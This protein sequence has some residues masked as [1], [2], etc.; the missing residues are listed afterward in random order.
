MK[1]MLRDRTYN[2][3]VISS[4]PCYMCT[5]KNSGCS[6]LSI[7]FCVKYGGFQPSDTKI[8]TL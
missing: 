7:E 8:F 4:N 6:N 1:M 3:G 2:C 5:L